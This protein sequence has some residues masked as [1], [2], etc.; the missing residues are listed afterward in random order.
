[1]DPISHQTKFEVMQPRSSVPGGLRVYVAYVVNFARLPTALHE[2]A[3]S[4]IMLSDY[5]G[6]Y[7]Q[8]LIRSC[9][10]V[11]LK[12]IVTRRYLNHWRPPEGARRSL[13]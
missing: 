5:F 8:I 7:Q 13:R 12:K 4:Q 9:D 3:W 11:N 6:P 2:V 1:M 10:T